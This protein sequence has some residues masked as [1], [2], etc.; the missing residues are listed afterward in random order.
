MIIKGPNYSQLRQLMPHLSAGFTD[1]SRLQ[2]TD[3]NYYHADN[4]HDDDIMNVVVESID[5]CGR[6]PGLIIIRLIS[7]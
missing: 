2:L 4:D 6:Y 3:N 7:H 1:D 5:C